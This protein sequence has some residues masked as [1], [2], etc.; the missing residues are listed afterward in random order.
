MRVWIL[1]SDVKFSFKTA[2]LLRAAGVDS[3]IRTNAE[4][5]S[6]SRGDVVLVNLDTVS[7][8]KWMQFSSFWEITHTENQSNERAHIHRPFDI[9][10]I[11]EVINDL[12]PKGLKRFPLSCSNCG[13]TISVSQIQIRSTRVMGPK[14]CPQCRLPGLNSHRSEIGLRDFR[15]AS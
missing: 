2:A 8:Y 6:P 1:D 14:K 13:N 15:E 5:V 7:D 3:I 10:D 11:L 4:S 12:S 9:D